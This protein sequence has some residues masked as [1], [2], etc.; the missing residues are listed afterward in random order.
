M[1]QKRVVGR[2]NSRELLQM[3]DRPRDHCGVVGVA[4][5]DEL[6]ATRTMRQ[7]LR[8]EGEYYLIPPENGHASYRI[9]SA[10]LQLQHRGQDSAGIATFDKFAGP[11]IHVNV[12]R[13]LVTQFSEREERAKKGHGPLERLPGS[14]GIGHVRYCTS[15]SPGLKD[16]QPIVFQVDNWRMAVAFNGTITNA[17][18][19]RES[20]RGDH[21]FHSSVDTEVLGALLAK[22]LRKG[23]G[24]EQALGEVAQQAEGGYAMVVLTSRGGGELAALRDPHGIRPLAMGQSDENAVMFA[25][26][27]VAL[28]ATGFSYWRMIKPGEVN[29]VYGTEPINLLTKQLV[30]AAQSVCQFEHVYFSRPDSLVDGPSSMPAVNSM[31]VGRSIYKVRFKLGEELARS[32]ATESMRSDPKNWAIV[33]VP[34]SSR[35]A[36]EGIASAIGIPVVEA[37]IKN[38]YIHRTFILPTP[39]E[40]KRAVTAKFHAVPDSVTGKSVIL[41]DDS[42]VRGTTISSPVRML[43]QAGAERVEVW[44]TEPPVVSYCP[45]GIDMANRDELIAAKE[46]VE[47]IRARIEADRLCYQTT[48]GLKRAIGLGDE[49]CT[50]CLTGKYPTPIAQQISDSLIGQKVVG[51]LVELKQ[52]PNGRVPA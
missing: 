27:T 38:R 48:E 32:Y 30:T 13:G 39:E 5:E 41:V 2:G 35:T 29:I 18:Q 43:R 15:A 17:G 34:D 1:S 33:P 28:H 6:S 10:L 40:R 23:R 3:A 12:V 11:E 9:Y 44:I 20:L 49:I 47:T 26:E 4:F 52:K 21:K 50:G 25:S 22:H 14:M 8:E 46:N 45:Y 7:R 37:L 24:L 42:I 16:A 51:R 19:L 36:S 31:V